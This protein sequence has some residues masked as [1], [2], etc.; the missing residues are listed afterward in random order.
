MVVTFL[1][2]T[3]RNDLVTIGTTSTI[4]S[5]ARQVDQMPRR[6]YTIRNTSTG[7]QVITVNLGLSQAVANNGIVLNP[8]ESFSDSSETGY[9]CFQGTITA[10]SD[11]ADGKLS[12]MER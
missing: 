11:L 10:I 12:I 5:F 8:N 1:Q 6:A 4:A 7:G 2:D 9:E 3:A